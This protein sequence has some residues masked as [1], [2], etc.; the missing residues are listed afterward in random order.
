MEAPIDISKLDRMQLRQLLTLVVSEV[1]P[2][3]TSKKTIENQRDA[4]FD[5]LNTGLSLDKKNPRQQYSVDTNQVYFIEHI[6]EDYQ[7]AQHNFKHN[8]STT[9]GT[10]LAATEIFKER[11]RK[12]IIDHLT[13]LQNNTP[14][15]GVPDFSEDTYNLPLP[16]ANWTN[17]FLNGG[18]PDLSSVI[19]S[20]VSARFQAEYQKAVEARDIANKYNNGGLFT[21]FLLRNKVEPGAGFV[22]TKH[23]TYQNFVDEWNQGFDGPYGHNF[24]HPSDIKLRDDWFD[25]IQNL[26]NHVPTLR[27]LCVELT[28]NKIYSY[29][30]SMGENFTESYHS[31]TNSTIFEPTETE[32]YTKQAEA[33]GSTLQDYYF[34]N[35]NV[36]RLYAWYQMRDIFNN[37]RQANKLMLSAL[38]TKFQDMDDRLQVY[39]LWIDYLEEGR[40]DS[41]KELINLYYSD[42]FHQDLL[43]SLQQINDN[44]VENTNAVMAEADRT[45][46]D[47]SIHTKEIRADLAD[48]I[49]ATNNLNQTVID[50]AEII[51]HGQTMIR[52]EV[53]KSADATVNA[54]RDVGSSIASAQVAQDAAISR[55]QANIAEINRSSPFVHL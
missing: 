45:R 22:P 5:G 4:L 47:L 21:K 50:C 36:T 17:R 3:D 44:V 25:Q 10:R 19:G 32:I 39:L 18:Q 33:S 31:L 30:R 15:I 1:A 23:S 12:A 2:F 34:A 29:G 43:N 35:D 20:D 7:L 48:S 52:E 14:K 16:I 38:P 37:M 26:D 13:K 54:I 53:G 40:A 28:P 9:R 11:L 8:Q 24:A 46:H 41:W 6:G 27:D 49:D 51:N 42:Q 55:I